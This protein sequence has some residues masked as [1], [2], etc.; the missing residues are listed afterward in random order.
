MLV[1]AEIVQDLG[2]DRGFLL[3]EIGF[4]SGAILQSTKRN[5][6]LTSLHDLR[7]AVKS[8]INEQV[9]SRLN[10]R[11]DRA[12]A[13]YWRRH[14]EEKKYLTGLL[15]S[16]HWFYLDYLS[17]VFDQAAR[18]LYPLVYK[19]DAALRLELIAHSIDELIPGVDELVS[20]AEK[21]LAAEPCPPE[22][23]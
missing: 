11:A 23:K 19:F 21:D 5:I 12:K 2:A 4:Q 8:G 3:S 6:T 15:I 10:W 7:E 17:V 22:E 14:Y 13:E 20:A 9:L 18:G 16:P 1:L